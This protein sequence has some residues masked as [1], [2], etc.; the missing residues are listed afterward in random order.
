MKKVTLPAN[1]HYNLQATE[2]Y[3]Y[4]RTLVNGITDPNGTPVAGRGLVTKIMHTDNTSQ[5][6]KYD[7]YGNKRWEY[8][9]L[10]QGTS[11]SYDD[12]KRVLSV[13]NPLGKITS[14]TYVPTNG[15]GGSSYL[16]TTNNPDTVTTPT[17]IMTSNVYDQNFR[18]T[19]TTTLAATTGFQYDNVGNLTLITD[20]RNYQ[21]HNTYDTRNRKQTT[22]EAYTTIWA[23]TTTWHYDGASN[24]YQIDRPDG[25]QETKT[26]DAMN[27]VL[28][29]VVPKTSTPTLERPR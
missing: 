22:T 7:A 24:I 9:E 25:T 10:G 23:E 3:E 15:G 14:Y 5:T 6:F 1:Y 13:T 27:R 12:Y 19:S 4:D 26:Y 18:K 21:T 8:N 16:H 11:Y 2:T 20:P 29:D 17:G 28:S